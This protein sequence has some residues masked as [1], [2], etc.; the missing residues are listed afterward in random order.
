M[1]YS[2]LKCLADKIAEIRQEKR[3]MK[4]YEWCVREA[5]RFEGLTYQ[6]RFLYAKTLYR[7][8]EWGKQKHR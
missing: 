3:N 1:T 8:V 4:L 2:E 7:A 5:K 6:E